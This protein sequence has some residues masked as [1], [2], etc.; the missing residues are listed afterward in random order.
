LSGTKGTLAGRYRLIQQSLL[1]QHTW[2]AMRPSS[3]HPQTPAGN[4]HLTLLVNGKAPGLFAK[5][6]TLLGACL[7]L[8]IAL[9]FSILVF[10][11]LASGVGVLLGVLAWKRWRA[12]RR[13][14][15]DMPRS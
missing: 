13:Q 1:L 14:V 12:N 5:V 6:L 3:D 10:A 7:L 11:V 2:H 4:H 8:S 15:W 9:V